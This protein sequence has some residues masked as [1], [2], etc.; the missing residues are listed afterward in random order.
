MVRV[1][2]TD[3]ALENLMAIGDY[4]EKDSYVYAQRVVDN[5]FSAVD[6]LEQNPFAGRKTGI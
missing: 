1:K 3:F 5:L 4:I 2:W 6:I